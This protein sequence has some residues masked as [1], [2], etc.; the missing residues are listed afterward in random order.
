MCILG[1]G[2]LARTRVGCDEIGIKDTNTYIHDMKSRVTERGQVTIPK[3][4]RDRLGIR[5]GQVLEF[6]EA[7]GRIVL[8]KRTPR[9]P[10]DELYG[11]LPSERSTDELMDQLRGPE[12]IS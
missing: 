10:V 5:A 1:P 12:P 8:S 4:L 7:G 6:E 11:S 9:D 3:E 2:L